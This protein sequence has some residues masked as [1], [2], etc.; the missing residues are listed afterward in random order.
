MKRFKIGWGI[1][2]V[3]LVSIGK[4]LILPGNHIL[5]DNFVDFSIAKV[6]NDFVL[7]NVV[8]RLPSALFQPC[9]QVIG[10]DLNKGFKAHVQVSGTLLLELFLP[11]QCFTA[12]AETTLTLLFALSCPVCILCDYIPRTTVFVLICRHLLP[13]FLLHRAFR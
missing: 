3:L 6:G 8:L 5:C 2:L 7:D 9:F 13:S 12:G 1:G 11:F 4:Q 10:I